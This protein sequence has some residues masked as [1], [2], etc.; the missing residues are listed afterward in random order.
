MKILI[1]GSTGLLGR[2]LMNEVAMR[3]HV[4]VITYHDRNPFDAVIRLDITDQDSVESAMKLVRPDV[5]I[6]AAGEGRVDW[7]E[8]NPQ[9]ALDIIMTGTNN[10]AMLCGKYKA[11]LF[12]I[13]SNAVY[14]GIC[15]PYADRDIQSPV[16]H[17]GVCKKKAEILSYCK[18]PI[19]ED[20]CIVRPILMY[21]NPSPGGR[22]NWAT[23]IIETYQQGKSMLYLVTDRITQPLYAGDA[24]AAILTLID[25]GARGCYNIGGGDVMSLYDFGRSVCNVMGFGYQGI[26]PITTKELQKQ[27]P[28]M[29][30]R[31]RD[32]HFAMDTWLLDHPAM[33]GVESGLRRMV[34]EE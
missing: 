7:C 23:A 9:K 4:G 21:G 8:K 25:E 34:N 24:A 16:N 31:P 10:V 11:K 33:P 20:L 14:G 18:I 6:H 32:T 15:A 22:G 13:S 17:Y 28:D 1:L 3:R 2:Y 29:A 12:Y 26:S 30:P 5:V 19:N 27:F